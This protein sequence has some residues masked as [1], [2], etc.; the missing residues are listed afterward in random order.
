[1]VL[2][3]RRLCALAGLADV[4]GGIGT[5]Y[6]ARSMLRICCCLH[7]ITSGAA[8]AAAGLLARLAV[9]PGSSWVRCA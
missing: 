8:A 3:S 5:M 4:T 6:E 9:Q 1:M 2:V 7:T